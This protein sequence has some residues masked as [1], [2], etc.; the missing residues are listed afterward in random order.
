[1]TGPNGGFVV[2]QFAVYEHY[3]SELSF[4]QWYVNPFE[5]FKACFGIADFPRPDTT[6]I[7]GRRIYYS[8]VD[9]DG[10]LNANETPGFQQNPPLS[11]EIIMREVVKPYPDLPVTI[12]PLQLI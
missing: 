9:G 3:E 4:R 6:T 7:A 2:G 5:F 11:S 10:W 1:M 12:G 8:H